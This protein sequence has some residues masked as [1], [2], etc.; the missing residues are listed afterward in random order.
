MRREVFD[1]WCEW[2]ILGLAMAILIIGPLAFGGV[3][4]STQVA[5]QGMALGMLVLWGAR[6]WLIPDY[7]LLW[8][9]ICWFVLLFVA[10]ALVRCQFV[11]VEY[12]ARQELIKVLV[13]AIVFFTLL[14]NCYGQTYTRILGLTL[15]AVA[16]LIAA[17]GIYQ[18]F[19]QPER[20]WH[21]L[22]ADQYDK[23]ATGTYFNPNHF[24]GLLELALPLGMAYA[25]LGRSAVVTRVLVVYGCGLMMVGIV[26]SQSRAG[27][28]CAAL[29]LLIVF[30]V[31]FFQRG[32]R[33]AAIIVTVICLAGGYYFFGR[34]DELRERLKA[35]QTEFKPGTYENVRFRIWRGA[36][37]IWQENQLWG[38]DPDHFDAHFRRFR[39][40]SPH[41]QL[42]PLR[43][44]NDYLNTLADWGL[45]G[46]GLVA[47]PWI[48]FALGLPKT[49]R[50]VRPAGHD[51]VTR[52]S[53]KAALVLGG[54]AGLAALMIHSAIDFNWHI[55][56]NA[57]IGVTLLALVSAHLR[58]ASERYWI[59]TSWLSRGAV[60]VVLV[61]LAGYLG[62]QTWRRGVETHWYE[63]AM[64][65]KVANAERLQA[66]ERAYAAEPHNAKITHAL[67]EHHR[68]LSWEGHKDY[69][70]HAREAIRWFELSA[71][72]N[73]LYPFVFIHWGMTLDWIKDY[74]AAEVC[75]QKALRL[76]PNNNLVVS[77]Y[78]W[79]EF[80]QGKYY[81]ARA[82]FARAQ[83]LTFEREG[84]LATTYQKYT[85]ARIAELEKAAVSK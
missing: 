8:P 43:A 76:D 10:Y 38:N 1:R 42:Q 79:H 62:Q 52:R 80:Q 3:C 57:I 18:Y 64:D 83:S 55:P 22:R 11:T 65:I 4:P 63:K 40:A 50:H 17:Y 45:V 14:N 58:F 46:A 72:D 75:F 71:A 30:G 70:A 20:I 25:I 9:P 26:L 28:V 23:R 31:L 32:Y 19:V 73:P 37:S 29:A 81:E 82:T 59:K 16:A 74:P 78:G 27:I 61:L 53:N 41:Y 34:S 24:A 2:G 21:I 54:S 12:L 84:H 56:A 51:L 49:W 35:Y 13:Y 68:A 5:L 47:L 15:I 44:H 66:L 69:A 39:V 36:V 48:F 85:D 60:T 77:Y 7:K 67:G 33:V 6:I